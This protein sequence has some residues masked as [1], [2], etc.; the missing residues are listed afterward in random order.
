MAKLKSFSENLVKDNAIDIS[1]VKKVLDEG[2]AKRDRIVGAAAQKTSG[3][4]RAKVAPK[5]RNPAIKHIRGPVAARCLN[6]VLT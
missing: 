2:K 1:D 3:D 5:Y 4:T 6:G